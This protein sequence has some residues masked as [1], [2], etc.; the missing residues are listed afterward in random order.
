MNVTGT[1]V[2][3]VITRTTRGDLVYDRTH[4]RPT[5]SWSPPEWDDSRP[6]VGTRRPTL[7][8]YTSASS[9]GKP[10]KTRRE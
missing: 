9:T 2:E 1:Q 3:T 7:V 8:A 5:G 10:L 4:S 6:T